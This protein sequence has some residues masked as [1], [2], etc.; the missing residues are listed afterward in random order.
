MS[1]RSVRIAWLMAVLVMSAA[2]AS[3]LHKLPRNSA[4]FPTLVVVVVVASTILD[5]I[6]TIIASQQDRTDS[7]RS[8]SELTNHVTS[9][10][11]SSVSTVL[12]STVSDSNSDSTVSDSNSTESDVSGPPEAEKID[13]ARATAGFLLAAA[14]V[15]LWGVLGFVLDTVLI[16]GLAPSLIG[17]RLRRLPV[18]IVASAAFAAIFMYLFY[19]AGGQPL[20]AGIFDITFG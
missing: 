17:F 7:S 2:Y 13:L 5:T 20:P 19:L 18:S 14:F 4:L 10:A 3:Q 6:R 11:N 8:S 12:D 16:A 9:S 15:G 1:V